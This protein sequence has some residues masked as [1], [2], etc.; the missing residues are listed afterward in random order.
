M[1]TEAFTK[2]PTGVRI[3]EESANSGIGVRSVQYAA[4]NNANIAID[5]VEGWHELGCLEEYDYTSSIE[6]YI[7]SGGVPEVDLG[8]RN[9]PLP[10]K[11][12]SFHLLRPASGYRTSCK[13]GRRR[14]HPV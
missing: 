12:K 4:W 10:L 5:G 9:A 1:T 13:P 2:V 3:K 11:P 6:E 14:Q 7:A 8:V